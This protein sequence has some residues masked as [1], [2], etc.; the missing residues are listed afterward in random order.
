MGLLAPHLWPRS[1][2]ET[3]VFFD[4]G[5]NTVDTNA[6]ATAHFP[7]SLYA[8]QQLVDLTHKRQA[9]L[10]GTRR[11]AA[12]PGAG[13]YVAF[14]RYIVPGATADQAPGNFLA[15]GSPEVTANANTADAL[16]DTGWFDIIPAARR[17]VVLAGMVSGGD[18]A[19]DPNWGIM[20]ALVR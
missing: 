3:V 5:Q 16:V 13:T 4:G 1:A 6:A 9:R 20:K 7:N 14:L 12:G 10:I 11:A 19:A 17:L 15:L 18:A 8:T 2:V